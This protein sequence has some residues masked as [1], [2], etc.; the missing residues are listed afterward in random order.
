MEEIEL[1]E[2]EANTQLRKLVMKYTLYFLERKKRLYAGFTTEQLI[3]YSRRKQL[4]IFPPNIYMP[5]MSNVFII[6]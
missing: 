1:L 4:H 5:F 2:T 3:I 6:V